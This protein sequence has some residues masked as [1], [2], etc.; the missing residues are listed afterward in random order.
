MT[1]KQRVAL[2]SVLASGFMATTKLAVGLLTGSLGILA[3]AAHS[4]LDLGAA[5]LTYVAVRV[6][7]RPPDESHPYGH[8]K[9]ESVSA[10]AET[11][12]LFLTSV[13]IVYEAV[14]RLLAEHVVVQST[15]WAAGVIVLA[16]VIDFLRARAL[17]T[18][19]R[20]TK[21]QALE[22]DALHFS[23]DML[24]SAV[25]LAGLGLVRIG[26]PQ[27]DAVAALGVAGFVC[28]AGWRLGKRTI[29]VLID[30]APEGIA[31]RIRELAGAMPAVVRID[32]VRVRSAGASLF[33]DLEVAVS[34]GHSLER[35]NDIR[36]ALADAIAAAHPEAEVAI[37]TRPIAVA[38][39]GIIDRV[40]LTAAK[41]GV[42][43]SRIGVQFV[44]GQPAIS[45][46]LEIAAHWT[47]G[48]AHTAATEF[49]NA[50]RNEIG[51]V[52][53]VETHI[54]PALAEDGDAGDVLATEL[55]ALTGRVLA[56]AQDHPGIQ[57]IHKVRARR[58]GN[59]LFVTLHCRLFREATM[60]TVHAAVDD[61]EQ[62]LLRRLRDVRRV[63]VHAEPLVANGRCSGASGDRAREPGP[64]T[65]R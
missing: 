57:D 61:F 49:E 52:I 30:T 40:R 38:E 31:N 33:V 46:T 65:R 19:A 53:E 17:T 15:W 20:A 5:L 58:S 36:C 62:D 56:I 28:I 55:A 41:H 59:G 35:V 43:V 42:A 29:D 26:W 63:V 11:A 47:L 25:V 54:E 64:G 1:D 45:L 4:L 14:E 6:S 50:I 13:W 37:S 8:A 34:R 16:I 27:G 51:S 48:D 39:E 60:E 21:S 3:E 7:D 44:G 2:S 32:R 18:V 9:V 24:S 10:L 22:A 12:L 23:S